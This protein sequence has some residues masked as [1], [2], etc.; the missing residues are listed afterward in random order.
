MATFSLAMALAQFETTG[1]DQSL[2][3][4]VQTWADEDV[5]EKMMQIN[6]FASKSFEFFSQF[7]ET[8]HP[9]GKL[10][11]LILPEVDFEVEESFGLIY[12]RYCMLITIFSVRHIGTRR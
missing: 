4:Y 6:Q 11:I 12:M 5:I 2:I 9:L 3:V 8:V 1:F 7:F 10:D